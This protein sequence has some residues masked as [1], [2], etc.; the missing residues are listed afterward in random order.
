MD[1]CCFAREVLAPVCVSHFRNEEDATEIKI[2]SRSELPRR[3]DNCK[4]LF[5]PMALEKEDLLAL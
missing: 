2:K 5:Y 3:V 1:T 4:E